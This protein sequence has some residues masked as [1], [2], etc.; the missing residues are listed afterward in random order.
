[1][2]MWHPLDLLMAPIYDDDGALRGLLSVDLP[3][4]RRRP[5]PEKRDELRRYAEQARRAVLTA[6]ERA[7]LAEQV[8]LADAARMI[9][10]EVSSELS[11]DRIIEVSQPALTTAFNS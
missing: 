11:M 2:E 7:E 8:R 10:R 3:R 1:A 9:V 4:D 5:G 6:F